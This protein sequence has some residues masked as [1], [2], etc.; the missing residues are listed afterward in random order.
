MMKCVYTYTSKIRLMIARV[1]LVLQQPSKSQACPV[2]LHSQNN[3][4]AHSDYFSS[5]VS[6]LD[7]HHML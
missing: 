3:Y 1:M 5:T 7:L 4:M 2:T 6:E